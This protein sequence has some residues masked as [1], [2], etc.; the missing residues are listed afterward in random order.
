MTW[1]Q[2]E[3]AIEFLTANQADQSAK[4]SQLIQ[5]TNQD[6]ENIRAL[7][8]IAELHERRKCRPD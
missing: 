8:R 7:V 4:T 3:R 2:M 6:A 5:M 1:E